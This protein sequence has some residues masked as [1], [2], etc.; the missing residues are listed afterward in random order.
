MSGPDQPRHPPPSADAPRPADGHADAG[1]GA[2]PPTRE[3]EGEGSPP[4]RP[5]GPPPFTRRH[6]W[7]LLAILV[8]AGLGWVAWLDWR[9]GSRLEGRW[10][11]VPAVVVARPLEL[12]PG[13]AL[14][15]TDLVREL[16][17]LGYAV[18]EGDADAVLARPGSYVDTR[19]GI[20]LHTR[21]FR[22]GRGQEPARAMHVRFDDGRI[23]RIDD[24][25]TG[26]R[27]SL[28]RVDPALVGSIFPGDGEDRILVGLDDVPETLVTALIEVEDRRYRTHP[29]VD[30]L[31]ILRAAWV[32][33]RAGRVVQGG[34]TLTQQVVRSAFLHNDRTLRRKINEAIMAL[35]LERRHDKDTVLELYLNEVYMGQHGRRAIHGFGLASHFYFDRPL[36][37]LALHEQALLVGMVKGP[38]VYDPRRRPD[39][40][41]ARRKVVL[42][43]LVEREVISR[44]EADAADAARLV[45]PRTRATRSAYHPAFLAVVRRDLAADYDEEVLSSDGLRIYTT[46]DPLVQADAEAALLE[47]LPDLESRYGLPPDSLEGAVVVTSPH[48]GEILAAVGGRD[49][50][51][52]GWN[53]A[54]TMK[55]QVGSVMKPLVYLAA[56]EA[57]YTLASTVV[58]SPLALPEPDGTTWTPRNFDREF[59]GEMPLCRA[60]L[61]SRNVPTVRLGLEVGM[62]RVAAMAPRLGLA[63]ELPSVP[64]LC[65]GA[66]PLSPLEVATLYGTIAAGGFASPPRA[67]REVLTADG[68]RLQRY[69]LEMATG[70]DPAVT[71]QIAEALVATARRGTGRALVD[72]RPAELVVG[73]KTGTT[74]DLRDSWFAGFSGDRVAVVWVG[75]DDNAPTRLTGSTGALRIWARVMAG[76]ADAPFAPPR[77][78]GVTQVWIDLE[79][80]KRS[81]DECVNAVRLPLPE[82]RVPTEDAE[83]GGRNVAERAVDWVKELFR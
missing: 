58:D 16:D 32:N 66:I 25:G 28:A 29:G 76:S 67:V 77:P 63:R 37:E 69:G 26:D 57:G 38:S 60:L 27:V 20:A 31:G 1:G 17:L 50:R 22:D 19:R 73:G 5:A 53:R 35:S 81:D 65:L 80:G 41:R 2:S 11:R 51:L 61:F 33:F 44:E 48:D 21:G 74:D 3:P 83:C 56:L 82:D 78:D 4:D 68:T 39:A 43:L 14:P 18:L 8:V 13:R 64:S 52:E 6:L 42:D 79:S 54:L 55:R 30:P 24:L 15:E 62:D 7:I 47:G 75:R 36:A 45:R 12:H 9:V 70:P 72:L 49:P 34:S 40:A 71:Y 23:E 46:L 59:L 10:W